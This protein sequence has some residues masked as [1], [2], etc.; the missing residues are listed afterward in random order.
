MKKNILFLL[1]LSLFF[2]SSNGSVLANCYGCA[3]AGCGSCSSNPVPYRCECTNAFDP[4]YGYETCSGVKDCSCE[5]SDPT[6]PAVTSAPPP[7]P[8]PPPPPTAT[9]APC[10]SCTV[11]SYGSDDSCSRFKNNAP[12]ISGLTIRNNLGN[13]VNPESG[14]RNQICQTEFNG[15]RTVSFVVSASDS[16]GDGLTYSITWNGRNI[17]MVG[18][19]GTITFDSSWNNPSLI[20]IMVNVSDGYTSSGDSSR[21]FKIWDCGVS[22]TGTGFDGSD[23]GAVCSDP[24]SFTIQIPNTLG[25][26]LLMNDVGPGAGTDKSMTVSSPTYSTGANPL[27]WGRDYVFEISNFGGAAPTQLRINGTCSNV[28]FSISNTISDPYVAAPSFVADFSSVLDQD[29]WWQTNNG[30]AISNNTINSR[31]PVTCKEDTCKISRSAL[32][33]SI[34]V[35]NKGRPLEACQSVFYSGNYAKLANVNTNYNYFYNQYF[36]KSGVGTTLIGDKNITDIGSTG[37]YFVDGNLNIAASKTILPGEFL[38]II[39]KGDINV[40]TT[41]LR[42][43]GILV[44]NNINAGGTSDSQ[45]VFNG[46]LF[47]FN[48]IDFSRGYTVKSNNNLNPAIVVNHNP[49]L[50]FNIPSSISKALTNW[51]WGN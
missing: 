51:Q 45:L 30:G 2:F 19:V 1:F 37:I 43:D 46:S 42:I 13:T 18:N 31:V 8:P 27:I 17:P 35:T 4:G 15:S 41:A 12:V 33:S 36:V 22:V 49:Q 32:A 50:L 44:A 20:P 23:V 34:T 3:T 26:N 39:V 24:N 14:S 25:Y 16:D 38:M 11:T 40:A 10:A 48:N 47:A 6:C 28:Q 21:Q 7:P 5:P 9:P 29:P